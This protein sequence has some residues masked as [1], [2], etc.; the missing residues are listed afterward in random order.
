MAIN[1]DDVFSKATKKEKSKTNV[2]EIPAPDDIKQKVSKFRDITSQIESLTSE[3]KII[4]QEISDFVIPEREKLIEKNGYF[5][6]AR[7]FSSSGDSITISFPNKYSKIPLEDYE[8]LQEILHDR[9]S[10][11]FR[12]KINISVKEDISEELLQE[13]VTKIGPERFAE[14]FEVQRWVEPTSRYSTERHLIP[15]E[16]R[17]KLDLF[18]KSSAPVFKTK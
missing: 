10:D 6:S 3:S 16:Q 2:V 14:F 5:T 12:K 13:L 18:V 8:N 9:T 11:F 17:E 4:A 1:L 15:K 7:L